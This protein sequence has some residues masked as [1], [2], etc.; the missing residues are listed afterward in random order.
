MSKSHL[1]NIDRNRC[2]GKAACV[3]ACPNDVFVVTKISDA[4]FASLSFIGRL[5]SRAHG[6]KTAYAIRESDCDGCVQCVEACP[7]SAIEVTAL[8]Q[9]GA[10]SRQ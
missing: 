2:E 1:V 5:K 7:E 9:A 4:D 3:A 10:E 8:P 6:R